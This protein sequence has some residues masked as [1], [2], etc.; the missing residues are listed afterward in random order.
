MISFSS[1]SQALK[2]I[3]N[4]TAMVCLLV[5]IT[6]GSTL[7]LSSCNKKTVKLPSGMVLTFLKDE[8]GET[9][10]EGDYIMAHVINKNQKDSVLFDTKTLPEPT[11]IKCGKPSYRGDLM[12]VLPYLSKG[13]S[14]E[15]A[16]SADSLFRSG[17]YPQGIKKG[18][19][20]KFFLSITQVWNSTDYKKHQEAL[21]EQQKQKDEQTITNFLKQNN[22]ADA[23]KTESGLYYKIE[24]EG[25]GNSPVPGDTVS[26]HYAGRLIDGKEF[27]NSFKRGE[28]ITFPLGMGRVIPGWDEGI[29]LLKIGGKGT[30]YIPSTLGYGAR[31]AGGVIPPNAVL[32][33][34]VELVSFKK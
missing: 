24:K 33:F 28:P 5:G 10:K 31:G 16:V 27:D 4:K 7:I 26:V 21:M 14:V 15:V 19:T 22:I 11:E 9:L 29:S 23:K 32:I 8:K 25:E 12:E 18:E 2:S 3:T 6:A 20:L 17:Q 13:D 30:L 34:D 1:Y